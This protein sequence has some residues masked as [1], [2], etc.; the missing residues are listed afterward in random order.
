MLGIEG[1]IFGCN[2]VFTYVA[3]SVDSVLW[4]TIIALGWIHMSC[5]RLRIWMILLLRLEVC[6]L[7]CFVSFLLLHVLNVYFPHY[8]SAN[9]T[10]MRWTIH[11]FLWIYHIIVSKLVPPSTSFL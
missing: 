1:V 2:I 3:I 6:L 11:T 9:A 5:P 4:Q 7:S 10:V 8:S